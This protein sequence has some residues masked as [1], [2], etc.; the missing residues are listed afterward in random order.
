MANPVLVNCAIGVWTPVAVNVTT[1]Q[2]KKLDSRPNLYFE[3]YC[4]TGNPAPTSRA[5]GVPM[6]QNSNAE[7]ISASAAIDVYIMAVGA[8]GRVRVDV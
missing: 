5:E 3:T 1:G 6:F 2:I 8:D 7:E 4:M